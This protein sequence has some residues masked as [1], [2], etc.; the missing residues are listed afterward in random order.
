MKTPV[1]HRVQYT[2][3]DLFALP[4]AEITPE[5]S[6]D[7]IE[8]WDSLQHLNLVLAIEQEFGVQFGPEDIAQILSVEDIVTLLTEKLRL[9][10]NP[11]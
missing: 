5:T 4:V 3:A 6:P 7:I 2:V 1:W 11:L 10:G 9:A 8:T